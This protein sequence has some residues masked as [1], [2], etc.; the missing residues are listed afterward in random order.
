MMLDLKGKKILYELYRDCRATSKHIAKKV[1]LSREAVDYRI[2][3]MEKEGI[4]HNYITLIDTPRLGYLTYNV[5][6]NLQNCTEKNEKEIITYLT[7]HPFTKWVVNC[8]GQWDLA[9][10]IAAKNTGHLNDILYEF[11]GK[12]KNKI[13]FY[14]ILSTLSV[15][16]DADVSLVIRD[17]ITEPKKSFSGVPPEDVYKLDNTD[18]NILSALSMNA[19]SNIVDIASKVNLTPEGTSYRMKRMIKNGLIRGFRAVLDVTKLGHLWYMLLIET[20][21]L[22]KDIEKKFATFCQLQKNIFFTDKLLG[23]WQMRVEILADNHQHLNT[24]MREIRNVLSEYVRSYELIIVFEELKQ[25]SF[26]KGMMKL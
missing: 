16:K 22:P 24:V 3:I 2:K 8:S 12:F 21:P 13:K 5:Y 17:N 25:V 26:T 19:R 10:A 1:G 6:I 18:M 15:Y 7:N 9:I 20:T 14:D 11:T 4:I 23:K